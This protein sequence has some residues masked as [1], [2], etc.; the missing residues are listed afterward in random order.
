MNYAI[1]WTGDQQDGGDDASDA[2]RQGPA[3]WT[4]PEPCISGDQL[5]CLLQRYKNRMIMVV[6]ADEAEDVV[7]RLNQESNDAAS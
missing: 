2:P 5:G 3:R 4:I 7:R 1:I 6:D